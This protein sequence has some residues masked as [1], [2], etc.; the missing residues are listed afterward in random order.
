M[1]RQYAPFGHVDGVKVL[2]G[3]VD[4]LGEVQR[5]DRWRYGAACRGR[6]ESRL[7]VEGLI[8][9]SCN[10]PQTLLAPFRFAGATPVLVLFAHSVALVFLDVIPSYTRSGSRARADPT[11]KSMTNDISKSQ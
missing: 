10:P 11:Q 2:A 7:W 8:T 5:W 1:G 3:V 9:G 4:V 6:T